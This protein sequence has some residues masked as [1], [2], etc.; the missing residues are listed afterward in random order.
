[1]PEDKRAI[2]GWYRAV[3]WHRR[4]GASLLV[5]EDGEV[6]Q[7]YPWSVAI[8]REALDE[9]GYSI[10]RVRI[11]SG[12]LTVTLDDPRDISVPTALECYT[13]P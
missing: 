3:R 1:M 10:D 11:E 2:N 7:V 12:R 4:L 5:L 8:P 6:V 13:F 9:M